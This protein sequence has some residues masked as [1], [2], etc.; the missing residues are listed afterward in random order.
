MQ[1]ADLLLLKPMQ[2]SV[3]EALAAAFTLHRADTA[4]D[5]DAFYRE[6]GPRIRA[7]ATGAQAPVDRAL[8]EKLPRLEIVA[9]FGVGYDTIDVAAAAERG[10]V[11][12]NT[13]D[14][15]SDE[16]A[17]LALGLLLATVREISQADR[18]LRA[19]HWP[20]RTY[21]LTATLRGRHVGILGLGRIGRAIAHRLEGFGVTLSYHG[22]RRQEDVAYAFHP[23]L[24]EM[25][26][27]V[28][29]LMIVAPGG[30]ETNGIVNA[31]IL[32]ALGP[33]GI[34]VNVARGSLVDEPAL[35]EALR[36]GTIHGAGLDVFA[37]E[38]HVPAAFLDLERVVL[39]PHVG[40]GSV[41]TREAMGRLVVDNLLSWFS[42]KGPL[43]PVPETPTNG[44]GTGAG[45]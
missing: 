28:D 3:M 29:V 16:V 22:R 31:E 39:L 20:T 26:R 44:R 23:T 40:S 17:D 7:M 25:A 2:P 45:R 9:S 24:L 33:D 37:A 12:T 8:I 13:P 30:P 15:L 36:S 32:E 19:G 14:V 11:V 1:P 21:P 10:I 43:T 41:H 38:P 5:P 42:G 18:Y 35:I 6:I 27:A 34:V 4:P